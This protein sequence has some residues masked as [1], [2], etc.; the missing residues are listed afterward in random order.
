M[1][2]QLLR[3]NLKLARS[4]WKSELNQIAVQL[5]KSLTDRYQFSIAEGDLIWLE[6][7][8]YVTHTG[9]VRLANRNR[10][11]GIH[12]KPAA[13]FCDPQMQRWS[14]EATVYKTSGLSQSNHY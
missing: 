1:A 7:G 12:T 3:S 14:F 13:G 6:R 2:N 11:A 5:L 10:C 8:W 4:R 9:L